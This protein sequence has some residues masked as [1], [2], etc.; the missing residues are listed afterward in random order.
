MYVCVYVYICVCV[1]VGV[2]V[3]PRVNLTPWLSLTVTLF[4]L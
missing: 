4:A 1:W 3:N 2:G